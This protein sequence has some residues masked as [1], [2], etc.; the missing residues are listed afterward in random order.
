[1]KRWYDEKHN[2]TIIYM[3]LPKNVQEEITVNEDGSYTAAISDKLCPAKQ[4]KAYLHA[5]NH[6]KHDDFED[7]KDVRQIEKRCHDEES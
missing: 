1:M 2:L 6:I 4:M 3:S 5:L 7:G